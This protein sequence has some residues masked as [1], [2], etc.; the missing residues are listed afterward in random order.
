MA[1]VNPVLGEIRSLRNS[2]YTMLQM[3]TLSIGVRKRLLSCHIYV[4]DF[5]R[6]VWLLGRLNPKLEPSY[7][8][9]VAWL[10]L[11]KAPFSTP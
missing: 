2:G 3:S 10:L 11:S 7:E 9:F 4:S 6:F 1:V 8:D 5:D